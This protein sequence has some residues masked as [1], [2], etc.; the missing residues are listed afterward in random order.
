MFFVSFAKDFKQPLSYKPMADSSANKISRFAA[1][2]GAS[3]KTCVKLAFSARKARLPKAGSTELPL[4]VLG[5]GPSLRQNLADDMPVL[6]MLPCMAVNFFANA[7]EFRTVR[8]R[9]YVL[10][11]PHFFDN[12]TTDGNV[13][14]LIDNIRAADWEM[15]L[16]IPA[17]A[18]GAARLFDGCKVSVGRFNFLAAEGFRWLENL[19]FRH[20]WAMPRPRNVLIPALMC[21][22]AM[23]Y[24]TI[25]VLGADHSWLKTLAVSD[26]N[27]VVS[28]QPHFYGDDAREKARVNSVY[29]GIKLHSVLESMM[30]AFRSYHIIERYAARCGASIINATPDS[31]IDAFRRGKLPNPKSQE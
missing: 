18:K 12:A 8:P 29:K 23:G 11:D 30:I 26:D 19:A 9:Y 25:Y 1:N 15:H 14:R 3:A 2:L 6:K 20:N 17:Q 16:L 24:K 22:L 13:A 28:V 7:P 5:N 31:M 27:T 4:V 10:A 21:S